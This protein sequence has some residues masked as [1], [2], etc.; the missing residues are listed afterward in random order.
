MVK[1][2]NNTPLSASLLSLSLSLLLVLLL[3]FITQKQQQPQQHTT[4]DALLFNSQSRG[5]IPVVDQWRIDNQGKLV[6]VVNGHPVIPDGDKITTSPLS[7]PD[8]ADGPEKIVTTLSGSRYKLKQPMA[9]Y[10]Q[11]IERGKADAAKKKPLPVRRTKAIVKDEI[12]LRRPSPPKQ[13][14]PL[15]KIS[16]RDDNNFT[17]RTGCSFVRSFV[18]SFACL[19]ACCDNLI[20]LFPSSFIVPRP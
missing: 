3:N 14:P 5:K 15:D 20:D 8:L 2:T 18:R 1:K 16:N 9:S 6:G 19:L 11:Q 12:G 10:K 7:N 4:A 17:V 13:K